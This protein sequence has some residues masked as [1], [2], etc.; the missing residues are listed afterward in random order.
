MDLEL[1]G[2][3]DVLFA[4]AKE[5]QADILADES[6]NQEYKDFIQKNQELVNEEDYLYIME[7][8]FK[9]GE[10]LF[11]AGAVLMN[12][13][14]LVVQGKGQVATSYQY[15]AALWNQLNQLD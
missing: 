12:S 8:V 2:H 9:Q 1:I 15:I 3:L 14:A 11:S 6:I 5:R 10:T 4:D 13:L 7:E